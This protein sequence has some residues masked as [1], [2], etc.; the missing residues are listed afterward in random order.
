MGVTLYTSRI[1]LAELGETD[2]GIYNVVGGV[3]VMFSFLNGAMSQSTQRFLSYELG[4][5]NEEQLKKTFKTALSIHLIIAIFILLLAETI[6]LWFLNNIMNIPPGQKIAANWVFQCSVLAYI[7]SVLQV[8]FNAAIIAREH[9]Q[10]FAIIGIIE[11]FFKLIIAFSLSLFRFEKLKIYSL[12]VLFVTLIVS[13]I[14]ILYCKRFFRECVLGWLYEKPLFR[15]MSKYAAW[16]TFGSLAWMGKTQGC[17][18]ILNIFFGPI[19]NAAYGISNQV[20][21]A[22]NSFVQ[23]FTTA[24]NP[25]IVKS[26]SQ[27]QYSEMQKLLTYGSKFAFLLIIIL[28]F[29]ILVAT[30]SILQKWLVEVPSY[31]VLFTQLV[32]VNSIIESFS[33]N[34]AAAIQATGKIKWYQIIVGGSILLN[35]PLSYIF[36]KLGYR[37]PIVFII[38]ICISI[39]TI[40]ERLSIMKVIIPQFSIYKFINV[41]LLPSMIICFLCGAIYWGIQYFDIISKFHFVTLIVL[42]FIVVC[43]LAYIIGLRKEERA[44]ICTYLRKKIAL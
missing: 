10:A 43:C 32:I 41:V 6:G 22:V 12:L 11:V 28:S 5:S 37:P 15:T 36:L 7:V 23:N 1:V 14:Y 44:L 16:N 25:Q 34:M 9:M 38:S 29:P 4:R 17:N 19:V 27:E 33:H 13:T 20:N 21:A 31:T 39:I 24:V 30:K 40:I 8:P 42:S 26:F 35:V 3:V 2:Y 18:I